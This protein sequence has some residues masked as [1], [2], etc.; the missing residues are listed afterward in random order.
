MSEVGAGRRSTR[1]Y[2]NNL[3]EATTLS[4]FKPGDKLYEDVYSQLCHIE[5]RI[6]YVNWTQS[7]EMMKSFEFISKITKSIRTTHYPER[8]LYVREKFPTEEEGFMQEKRRKMEDL[9]AEL[10][11]LKLEHER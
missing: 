7:E 10:A 6:A 8:A 4:T 5:G 2:I 11:I 9:E 3:R 1:L